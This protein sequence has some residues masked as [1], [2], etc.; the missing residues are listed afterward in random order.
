MKESSASSETA[1]LRLDLGLG[2][3][4]QRVE[5][6]IFVE[7]EF[8]TLAVDGAT[9]GEEETRYAGP[10]GEVRQADRGVAVDVEGDLGVQLTH[11]IVGDRCQVHDA[12]APV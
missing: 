2:V 10:L 1:L 3:G 8:L 7:V 9:P 11:R 12:V 6:V 4:G 5:R